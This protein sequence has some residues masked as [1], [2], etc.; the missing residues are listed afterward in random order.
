MNK[1]IN[2]ATNPDDK[3]IAA[4]LPLIAEGI[5]AGASAMGLDMPPRIAEVLGRFLLELQ[6]W[7]RA[8]NL[9]GVREIAEMVPRHILDSLSLVPHIK[10]DTLVDVGSGAGLPGLPLAMFR[11][12]LKVQLIEANAH[13][14]A[15]LRHVV[16]LLR[17]ENVAVAQGRVQNWHHN[18]GFENVVSRAFAPPKKFIALCSPLVCGGGQMLLMCGPSAPSLEDLAFSSPG[19]KAAREQ[20]VN[21]PGLPGQRRIIVL[22]Q[23]LFSTSNRLH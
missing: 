8:I 1:D 20:R 14:A 6:K 21:I 18:Q 2:G 12:Q 11:P 23:Q 7:S 5:R 9:T 16:R 10:G 13:K 17:M 3:K 4:T 15:F 19:L 22:Q